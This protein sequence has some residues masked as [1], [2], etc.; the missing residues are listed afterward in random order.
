MQAAW[1]AG[2]IV[3]LDHRYRLSP[4]VKLRRERFGALLYDR[5]RGHLYSLSPPLVA[6]LSELIQGKTPGEVL[7]TSSGESALRGSS[8]VVKA[9]EKL[10]RI[11]VI[12][13]L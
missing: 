3:Q 9:L 4:K 1:Q 12:N 2:V 7:E 10:E 5:E 8:K 6:A 11:G 13:E